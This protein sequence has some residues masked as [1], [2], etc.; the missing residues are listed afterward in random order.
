MYRYFWTTAAAMLLCGNVPNAGAASPWGK[1]YFPNVILTTQDGESL[2]FFDDLIEG[3][4]VA[5]NFIYTTCPD[6]CPLETAQLVKVQ[7]ILGE[8]M[9]KEVFFYSITIDPENDTPPVLREYRERFGAGWTFLTGDNADIIELRKKLGLYIE[10]IQD[11][12]NNH[13]VSMIIGN[14][15]TGRWMK[16]SPFENTYV[17]ADQLGNWLS[18]WKGAQQERD[19]ASAPKLRSIPRGEQL[20]RTRCANCHSVT[21]NEQEDALGPD[22]LGVTRQRDMDWLLNWLRAPDQMLAKKDPVAMALYKKY[23]RLAMP[24]M[25]LNQ[26]DAT[27]LISYIDEETQRL[28]AAGGQKYPETTVTEMLTVSREEPAGGVVAITNA[29]VRE[30]DSKAK[31]NAGYMT[32]LNVGPEQVTLVKVESE[33][34]E[35]IEVHEMAVVDGLM[36][37]R[38]VTDMIIPANGQ[39]QFKPG[40][41]HLMLKKPHRHLIAGQKVDM[42]L[43]FGSGRKQLLSV[44]VAAR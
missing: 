33:S 13:N 39:I 32:L 22:L 23:N 37:M 15:A 28:A 14:Q 2:R 31:V 38:E 36:E 10:E 3:K 19:Y 35:I 44:N 25:R 26:Q 43:T 11:G 8:R 29:W 18:G 34:Y 20:F 4:V 21:G 40:G 7:N 12:S 30:T 24:N 16:R 9:G 17:L 5:I 42:T 6:T 27:A 1:D 41:M